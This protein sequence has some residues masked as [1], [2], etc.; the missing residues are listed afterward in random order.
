VK[1]RLCNSYS[2][3]PEWHRGR[4]YAE[5]YYGIPLIGTEGKVLG[6]VCHFDVLPVPV[7]KDISATLDELGPIVFDAAFKAAD[8][9]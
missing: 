7:T 9:K 1:W 3:R 5:S 2:F 8:G 6:T 4:H